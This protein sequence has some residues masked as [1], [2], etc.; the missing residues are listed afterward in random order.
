MLDAITG[1]DIA[2]MA[3]THQTDSLPLRILRF[4][5][6]DA[7]DD[8]RGLLRRLNENRAFQRYLQTRKL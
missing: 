6:L 1:M 7:I 2:P 5:L 3:I 4:V 8:A